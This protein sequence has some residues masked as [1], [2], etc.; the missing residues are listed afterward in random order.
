M[1]E[2]N[3]PGRLQNMRNNTTSTATTQLDLCQRPVSS[4]RQVRG[5]A[6]VAAVA[7]DL[8]IGR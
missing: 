7:E 1:C 5:T 8:L 4:E 6:V 3:C 2:V